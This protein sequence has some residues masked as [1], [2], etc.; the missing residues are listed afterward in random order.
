[1][2]RRLK[3]RLDRDQ[4]FGN[5]GVTVGRHGALRRKILTTVMGARHDGVQI[6]AGANSDRDDIMS[7]NISTRRLGV[8][9]I[10]AFALLLL[11]GSETLAQPVRYELFPEPDVRQTATNRT[12]SAYIVDKKDNQF[13]IC[14]A[15][16]DF[17][18]LT[19]NNGDCV[20]LLDIGRPTLTEN[21]DARAP[22][23]KRIGNRRLIGSRHAIQQSLAAPVRGASSNISSLTES[24]AITGLAGE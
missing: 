15:R 4:F 21:Y 8:G 19:A 24:N 1:M 17:R 9:N 3:S 10:L 16:Y 6:V 5:I 2:I 18:D 22:A 13:W 14:T 11:R 7:A 12:A 23:A 20:K